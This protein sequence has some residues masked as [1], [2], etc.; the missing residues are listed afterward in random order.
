MG[1]VVPDYDQ[2]ATSFDQRYDV[3]SYPGI[4]TA[5]VQLVRGRAARRV[6]EVGC[7]TGHWLREL[8]LPGSFTAGLD[9]SRA[10]L[11]EAQKKTGA[12]R[13]VCGA[14]ASLPFAEQEFDLTC[15]INAFHHFTQ[16]ERFLVEAS[17]VL[18]PGG[19][20]AIVGLDPHKPD[21]R[22]YLYDYFEGVREWDHTRYDSAEQLAARLEQAAFG[23]VTSAVVET[24]S[25]TWRGDEVWNDLFL[26]KE[27]TSQLMRLSGEAYGAGLER[28]KRVIAD[29]S[30]E[31]MPTFR[32]EL[33]LVMT[34]GVRSWGAAHDW[35]PV[36]STW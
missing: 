27:S 36:P 25:R 15:C 3:R 12:A 5:L 1:N 23:E 11:H 7:G 18:K 9:K 32:V 26:R 29:S 16:P 2:F 31:R 24:I 4:R 13:L 28:M 22:W 35:R 21:T 6:L 19:V 8:D 30:A 34:T 33:R 17:R 14:A 20:L 10:M